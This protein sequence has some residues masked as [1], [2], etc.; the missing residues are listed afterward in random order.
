MEVALAKARTA[1]RG[2][3]IDAM[4]QSIGQLRRSREQRDKDELR[5][6]NAAISSPDLEQ[7]QHCEDKQGALGSRV[8]AGASASEIGP[9]VG[10]SQR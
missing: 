6:Q 9:P 2:R 1:V 5:P 7:W 8:L 10:V 4:R 3:A